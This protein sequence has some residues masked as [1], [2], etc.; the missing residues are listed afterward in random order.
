M[1]VQL[2]IIYTGLPQLGI[3]LGVVASAL[4]GLGVNESAYIAEIIRAGI[5]GFCA[6]GTVRGGGVAL[7]MKPGKVMRWI[8]VPQALRVMV[9]PLGNSFNGMM[10]TTSV[11]SVIGVERDVPGHPVDQLVH[12]FFTPSRSS[13]WWPSTTWR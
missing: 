9:P 11:L 6:Q 12:L 4:I 7:G 13:S 2:I 1:L 3:K 5:F 10:K 8:I